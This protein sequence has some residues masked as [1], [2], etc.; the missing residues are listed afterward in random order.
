M[1]RN[2]SVMNHDII[3]LTETDVLYGEM[4]LYMYIY[5]Y[6]TN[7]AVF[8]YMHACVQYQHKLIGLVSF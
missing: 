1:V 8:Y 2:F 7:S 5:V 6:I 4:S 3:D